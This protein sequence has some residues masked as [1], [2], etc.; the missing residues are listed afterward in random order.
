MPESKSGAKARAKRVGI[1]VSQVVRAK[2]GGYFIA[3]RGVTG[4]AKKAYA[5]CRSHGGSKVKCA[6]IAHSI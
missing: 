6:K 4:G 2:S 5:E 1:P 3:P